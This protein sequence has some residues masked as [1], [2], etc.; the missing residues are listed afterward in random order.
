MDIL[1]CQII[2]R[3]EGKELVMTSYQV[4]EPSF[5]PNTF[6]LDLEFEARK[7]SN[8]FS[9]N[10]S[11][12][13]PSPMLSIKTSFKEKIVY[14]K[15]AEEMAC[16]LIVEN[17]SLAATYPDGCMAYMMCMTGPV[18]VVTTERSFFSN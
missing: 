3:F 12:L 13:F 16:F 17:A 6:H 15:S 14:L 8:K 5:R 11:Q 1:S 9:D 4:F 7:F 18:T 10:I 2:N